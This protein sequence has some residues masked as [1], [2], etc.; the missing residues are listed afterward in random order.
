MP[1]THR[2]IKEDLE[3]VGS[4]FD[5]APDLEF[6]LAT[7]AL[8]LEKS[9]LCYQRPAYEPL[10]RERAP[11][12]E[13]GLPQVA[14]CDS[15]VTGGRGARGAIGSRRAVHAQEPQGGPGGRRVQLRRRAGSRVP[16]GNPGTRPCEIR[17]ELPARTAH[18]PME[19]ECATRLPEDGPTE[20]AA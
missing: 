3:D 19:R 13:S 7:E 18:E 17:L 4:N 16:H 11:V 8:E 10:E 1:F 14:R 12:T 2:N 9:G 20:A 15:I 5:G 6:R